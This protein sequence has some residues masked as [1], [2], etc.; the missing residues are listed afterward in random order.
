MFLGKNLV[1]EFEDIYKKIYE[2]IV[3]NSKII[4][5]I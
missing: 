1:C 2:I 4:Y 5:K 3:Y